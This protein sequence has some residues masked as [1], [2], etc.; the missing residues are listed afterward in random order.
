MKKT[1]SFLCYTT[2]ILILTILIFS[3][4]NETV[5]GTFEGGS[6]GEEASPDP[7]NPDDYDP[8]ED[9]KRDNPNYELFAE[10]VKENPELL[11]ELPPE[12]YLEAAEFLGPEYI[13]QYCDSLSDED[14][15]SIY[16]ADPPESCKQF[17]D[18][19]D[20]LSDEQKQEIMDRV[21]DSALPLFN[22][23]PNSHDP[24]IRDEF[25]ERIAPKNENFT[26]ELSHVQDSQII[27]NEDGTY[28]LIV[29]DNEIYLDSISQHR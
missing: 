7:Y 15:E 3:F 12:K 29:G 9:I 2:L 18:T 27:E 26:V 24:A 13:E 11:N 5:L 21:T 28:S 16:Y 25:F 10:A 6:E 8:A 20:G 1:Y 19:L 23:Q 22:E 4:L 14:L 17:I